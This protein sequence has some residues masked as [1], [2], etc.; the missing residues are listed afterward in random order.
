MV[1]KMTLRTTL[2]TVVRKKKICQFCKREFEGIKRQLYCSKKCA[3]EYR[4]REHAKKNKKPN[5]KSLTKI[6]NPLCEIQGIEIRYTRHIEHDEPMYEKGSYTKRNP[7]F[8]TYTDE[9]IWFLSREHNRNLSLKTVKE[10]I[11]DIARI[12]IHNGYDVKDPRAFNRDFKRAMK[13]LL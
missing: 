12:L 11:G 6:K 7:N 10:R 2:R 4:K 5:T 9:L 3:Y 13:D 8:R 1:I